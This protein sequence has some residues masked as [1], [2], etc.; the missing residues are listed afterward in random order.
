[1]GVWYAVIGWRH[2]LTLTFNAVTSR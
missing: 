2:V 1:V